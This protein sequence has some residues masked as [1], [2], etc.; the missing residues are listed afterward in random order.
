MY[1]GKRETPGGRAG[2]SLLVQAVL[3]GCLVLLGVL[4]STSQS[5]ASPA[6]PQQHVKGLS[7]NVEVGRLP[8]QVGSARRRQDQPA[9]KLPCDFAASVCCSLACS[10]GCLCRLPY[11]AFPQLPPALCS[12]DCCMSQM[13]GAG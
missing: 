9:A 13:Q 5:P 1:P 8:R 12:L 7:L 6:P 10:R 4:W 11:V 2:P 3:A